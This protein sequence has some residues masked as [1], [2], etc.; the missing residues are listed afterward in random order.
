M[1]YYNYTSVPTK[2]AGDVWYDTTISQLMYYDGNN[3]STIYKSPK[4]II[5]EY[6]EQYPELISEIDLEIRK[7]KI[8]KL[9]K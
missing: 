2:N 7:L 5:L 1:A 9:N 8:Q 6:F 3:S 4:E